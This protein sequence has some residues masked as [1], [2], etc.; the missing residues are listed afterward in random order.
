MR[1]REVIAHRR[2]YSRIALAADDGVDDPY[3]GHGG[4]VADDR[5]QLL[6]HQGQRLLHARHVRGGIFEMPVA[7][8]QLGPQ[9]GDVAFGPKHARSSTHECDCRSHCA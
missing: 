5:T 7:Q 3:P 9:V 4:Q 2:Q 1:T 8:P 6:V